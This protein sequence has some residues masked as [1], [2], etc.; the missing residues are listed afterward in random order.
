V[1]DL[2]RLKAETSL[3]LC[4][5]SISHPEVAGLTRINRVN[6]EADPETPDFEQH[7]GEG[8]WQ[9]LEA[10][11]EEFLHDTFRKLMITTHCISNKLLMINNLQLS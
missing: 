10:L 4:T 11:W 7:L 2:C 5:L 1:E 9:D 6:T 8:Q 3:P